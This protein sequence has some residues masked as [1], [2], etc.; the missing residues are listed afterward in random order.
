MIRFRGRSLWIT[1]IKNKPESIGFKIY[2]VASDGYLL[3]F[4]IFRGKGG[5][6]TAQDVLM[7]TVVDLVKPWGEVNRTLYFDNLYTSPALWSFAADV[8]PFLWHLSTQPQDPPHQPQAGQA[9]TSQG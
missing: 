4:R 7:H 5:Y 6:D 8:A 2:T 3:G 9:A 1:V